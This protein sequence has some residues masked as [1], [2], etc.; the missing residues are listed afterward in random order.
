VPDLSQQSPAMEATRQL[1]GF[2]TPPPMLLIVRLTSN[3]AVM[4]EAVNGRAVNVLG[5]TT[6]AAI[7]SATRGLVWS[8]FR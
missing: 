4:G 3:R 5:W 6:T 1:Q 8:W 7:F 2:S